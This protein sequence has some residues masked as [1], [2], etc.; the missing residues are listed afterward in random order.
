VTPGAAAA[1][2]RLG[3][4]SATKPEVVL[5]IVCVG[6]ILANLDLFVVIVA[7]PNI[8]RDL[9][10]GSLENLSWIINA[11]GIT[12]A[13][14]LVFF[15]RLAERHRR[16][17]SFLLGVAAFTA[18]SAACAAAG[19]IATLVAFR[20]VQAAGAALMTPTSIGLILAAFPPD[21]RSGAVRAW[22]AI[23]GFGAALG[24]LVGGVILLFDW[25]WIFLINIPIGVVALL[26]GK[27]KLPAVSGHAVARPSLPA[28]LLVSAGT[29]ALTI[30]IVK[31]NEWGWRSPATALSLAA[32][33]LSIGLFVV[34][35]MRSA[36]PFVAPALFRMRQ[37]SGAV[38]VMAPYSIAFGGMLLSIPLWEQTVW[39]WSALKTG[40]AF[41]VGSALVPVT[42]L[43]LAG[44]L[45]GRYGASAVV[46][47]GIVVFTAGMLFW[48]AL[49]RAEPDFGLAIL[50]T[51]P[52]GVGVGLAFPTLMGV[53]AAALPPSSFSTG[54][55]VIN[56]IRQVA[57]AIGVAIF[58][59]IL[60][61]AVA[62]DQ[63][64]QR[65]ELGWWTM[66]AIT[67]LGLI[68]TLVLIRPKRA[69]G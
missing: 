59:A 17:L 49:S 51:V 3:D 43:L 8:G 56:M 15:G 33:L 14:L 44:R 36:N 54:S 57:L 29:A 58:V 68:P 25:R 5:A 64:P 20:V 41:A 37:Y 38:L 60:S 35:C 30:V 34:H 6:M 69:A 46:I 18:A 19:S 9:R 32:A 61:S 24:P 22:T 39:G 1:A 65:F 4:R 28:A 26:I 12:Y 50:A 2:A 66:A 16:D 21:R 63:R 53:G 52:L 27:W 31:A 10:D 40:A 11:Y 67:A 48:A 62:P 47:A 7:L 45:I 23:G 55:G 42:S 13:A